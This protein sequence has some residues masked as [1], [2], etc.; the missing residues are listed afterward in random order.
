MKDGDR[1]VLCFLLALAFLFTGHHILGIIV[2]FVG[3][4]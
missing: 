2:F 4:A 3:L 1:K